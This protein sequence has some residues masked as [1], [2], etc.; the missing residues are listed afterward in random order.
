MNILLGLLDI[1]ANLILAND[2]NQCVLT[3]G[4]ISNNVLKQPDNTSTVQLFSL[5]LESWA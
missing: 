2:T 1:L 5:I 3:P 4:I